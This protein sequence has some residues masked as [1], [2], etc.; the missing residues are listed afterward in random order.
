MKDSGCRFDKN[1][2]LI[3]NFYKTGEVTGRSYAKVPHR[4]NAILNVENDDK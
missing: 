3:V 2:S 4:S 1:N